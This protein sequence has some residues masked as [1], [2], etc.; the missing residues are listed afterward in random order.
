M[1][2]L[3]FSILFIFC[4]SISYKNAKS[5]NWCKVIYNQNMTDGQLHAQLS[6]CKNSD[7]FSRV[8]GM[9]SCTLRMAYKELVYKE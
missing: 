9:V 7:N 6:K 2:K 8:S 3:L 4:L 5:A 1:K